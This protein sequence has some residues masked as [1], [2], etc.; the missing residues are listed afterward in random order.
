MFTALCTGHILTQWHWRNSGHYCGAFPSLHLL[1]VYYST[2]SVHWCSGA[3]SLMLPCTI[4]L[5]N[6]MVLC[7]STAEKNKRNGRFCH[8]QHYNLWR[9]TVP[10]FILAFQGAKEF[11]LV[12]WRR[13][14]IHTLAMAAAG[15][16]YSLFPGCCHFPCKRIK[17]LC[18]AQ[19]VQLSQIC[20]DQWYSVI[21]V[22]WYCLF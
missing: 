12:Y 8:W 10:G 9:H 16:Y 17:K 19:T 20:S 5:G 3:S 13:F 1:Q 14:C 2:V 6:N 4:S 18:T 7:V 22:F 11:Q 15:S 21:M